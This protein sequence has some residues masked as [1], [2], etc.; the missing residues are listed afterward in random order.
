[1]KWTKLCPFCERI[2]KGEFDEHFF[3]G[4]VVSFEPLNPVTEG[5]RLF[6]PS[7]H[8]EHQERSMLASYKVAQSMGAAEIW[9]NRFDQDFNLI[10]SAGR[11]ATQTVPHIHIHY[12]PRREG[13]GLLL[14]WGGPHA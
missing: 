10:T 8:V 7:E 9:A 11:S 4:M 14:P 2:H 6:V 5:H 1:M 3:E 13:D 12:V